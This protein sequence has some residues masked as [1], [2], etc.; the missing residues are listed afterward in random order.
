MFSVGQMSE[1]E[2]LLNEVVNTGRRL[3]SATKRFSSWLDTLL[4]QERFGG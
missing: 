2:E 3:A 1:K 4:Y